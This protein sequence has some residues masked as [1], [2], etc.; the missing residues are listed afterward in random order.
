MNALTPGN[1]MAGIQNDNRELIP[2][3][4]SRILHVHHEY[5]IPLQLSVMM[6]FKVL[7]VTQSEVADRAGVDKTMVYKSLAG[8]RTS[9]TRLKQEMFSIFGM[10]VWEY[11]ADTRREPIATGSRKRGDA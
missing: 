8:L 3:G 11:H 4:V 10:D 1:A 7:K 5:Q 9:P 2:H 6:L